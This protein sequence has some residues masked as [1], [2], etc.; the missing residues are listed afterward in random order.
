MKRHEKAIQQEVF[1]TL[2]T[3][4]KVTYVELDEQ[5]IGVT[6]D[7]YAMFPLLRKD[8]KFDL[9]KCKDATETLLAACKP[10]E[11]H[12][13]I[14]PTNQARIINSSKKW[15]L[16]LF[17]GDGARVW[18][19]PDIYKRFLEFEVEASKYPV[20]RFYAKRERPEVNPILIET[21]E[22]QFAAL[23]LP[24]RVSDEIIDIDDA[25]EAHNG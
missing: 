11:Q 15:Y 21:K 5:Y 23:V 4:G 19:N 24:V 2:L 16:R 7:G 3:G 13:Q 6:S 20:Y 9:A 22:G 18:A 25:K 17:S 1:K 12:V 10:S 14:A 8:I